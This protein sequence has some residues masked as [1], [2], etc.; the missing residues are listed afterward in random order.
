MMLDKCCVPSKCFPCEAVK[1]GCIEE[2]YAQVEKWDGLYSKLNTI[3]LRF[4]IENERLRKLVEQ[5]IGDMDME[6]LEVESYKQALK[7]DSNANKS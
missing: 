1:N 4:E 5:A 6:G 2:L 3:R 7:G